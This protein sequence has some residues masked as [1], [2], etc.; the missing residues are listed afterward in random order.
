M[1]KHLTP[2]L[3][4]IVAT[5]VFASSAFAWR[6]V[7]TGQ[8]NFERAWSAYLF[9]RP[10]RADKYFTK[11]A[12]A[13]GE[14]LAENPPSRTTMF[15]SNLTMAGMSLY[16]AGRYQ[17]AVDAMDKARS[18]DRRIWETYLFSALAYA[19]M[20][21]KGEA[22]KSME[23]FLNASPGQPILSNAV[24]H[25]LTDLQTDSGTLETAVTVIEKATAQQYENNYTLTNTPN[26]AERCNG[27]YWWRYNKAPCAAN[28]NFDR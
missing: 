28:P 22:I 2:L 5:T 24:Q 12:N 6:S 27:N 16:Y 18:K 1:K 4:V 19:S 13:F 15:A 26:P 21:D 11:A 25:Q 9:K 20:Q 8:K 14:A 7:R 23:A 10:D 17:E 3:I